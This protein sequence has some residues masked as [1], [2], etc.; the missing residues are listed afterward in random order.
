MKPSIM[1]RW[2]AI[3]LVLVATAGCDQAT[4]HFARSRFNAAEPTVVASGLMEFTLAENP[5]A[6]LSLGETLPP[7]LREGILTVGTGLGLAALLAYLLR[8][9]SF[10]LLPFSGLLLAWAGGVSNLIDRLFRH[11]TVTDFMIMRAGP[12]HTGVFNLA[13]MAILAGIAIVLVGAFLNG[14]TPESTEAKML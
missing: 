3:L 11:G 6:F 1:A 8:G 7:V 13:D 12:L 9:A 5:G 4:K 2:I 14:R 10:K